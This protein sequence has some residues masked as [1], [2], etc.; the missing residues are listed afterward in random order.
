MDEETESQSSSQ[1]ISGIALALHQV[2]W[3]FLHPQ[4]INGQMKAQP[5]LLLMTPPVSP[6][7]FVPLV[8][9]TRQ[10]KVKKNTKLGKTEATEEN[11]SHSPNP[12]S[13][14]TQ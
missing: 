2:H 1:E 12:D 8:P 13:R 4:Q 7:T 9:R 14:V 5:G 3:L 11:P 10:A 6:L